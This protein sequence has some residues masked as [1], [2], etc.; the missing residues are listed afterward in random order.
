MEIK[1]AEELLIELQEEV[2]G[3][4]ADCVGDNFKKVIKIMKIHAE[5]FMDLA[6]YETDYKHNDNVSTISIKKLVEIK[7]KIL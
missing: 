5:Q 3:C 1:T 7:N 4:F 2:R 6:I